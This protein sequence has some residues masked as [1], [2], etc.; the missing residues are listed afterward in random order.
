MP[1]SAPEYV[2][3]FPTLRC[4]LSCGFCFTRTMPGHSDM[5][6]GDFRRLLAVLSRAGVPEVDVL[7]GEPT[8]HPGF[9]EM[10]EELQSG[11]FSASISSNGTEVGAL[12]EA[13]DRH[14]GERLRIGIS[15]NSPGIS[16]ELHGF[17]LRRRP[18]LKSVYSKRG[19][20]PEALER[21]AGLEEIE[22]YLIYMDAVRREDLDYAAPFHEYHRELERL[23]GRLGNLSGVHCG[24]V[25]EDGAGAGCPAG[26]TKL[27]VMPDGS[28]WPCYLLAG[29]EE[30][31]LGNVLADDFSEIWGHPCLE[32]FRRMG[33]RD[34][35]E[36]SCRL[37][38]SCAGGC[39][40]VS[41][42]AAGDILAPEPRCAPAVDRTIAPGL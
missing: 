10:L 5:D 22:Y 16:D 8:A 1:P 27:T 42:L 35:P 34:C 12:E 6:L 13:A 41:L 7:G 21:Y 38:A 11:G 39:P 25:A 9:H 30:F 20:V 31:R 40:G 29:R 4:G 24:F 3:F 15:L 28:A 14:P 37:R 18:M 32:T 2:Q 36:S 26:T 17:I 19:G 23:K 33:K